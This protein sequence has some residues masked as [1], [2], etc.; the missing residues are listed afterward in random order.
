L[1][2]IRPISNTGQVITKKKIK[3]WGKGHEYNGPRGA[4][5]DESIRSSNRRIALPW[6]N[7]FIRRWAVLALL[8][9]CIACCASWLEWVFLEV[10]ATL[11]SIAA[12]SVALFLVLLRNNMRNVEK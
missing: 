7:T 4:V 10:P 9:L 3:A 8:L 11:A 2:G 1:G 5:G 12:L 6:M